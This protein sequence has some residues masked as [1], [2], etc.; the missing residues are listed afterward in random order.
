MQ[1][2][3]YPLNADIGGKD[4]YKGKKYMFQTGIAH[5]DLVIWPHNDL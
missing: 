2:K 5:L 1:F 4:W 3:Y